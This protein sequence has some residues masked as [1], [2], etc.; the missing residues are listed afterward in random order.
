M[1]KGNLFPFLFKFGA[2]FSTDISDSGENLV[3]LFKEI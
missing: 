2:A 3:L 1:E